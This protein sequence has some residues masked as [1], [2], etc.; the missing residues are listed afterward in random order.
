MYIYKVITWT[1]ANLSWGV[2]IDGLVLAEEG[3]TQ[4]RPGGGRRRGRVAGA[5]ALG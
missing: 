1:Y 2:L 3:S 5:G 4:G